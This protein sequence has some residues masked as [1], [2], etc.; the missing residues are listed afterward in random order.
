MAINS[1]AAANGPMTHWSENAE[2]VSGLEPAHLLINRHTIEV[3]CRA[4]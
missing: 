3:I 2:S 4:P 1:E